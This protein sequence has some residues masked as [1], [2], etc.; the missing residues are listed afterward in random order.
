MAIKHGG[1]DKKTL[2]GQSSIIFALSMILA[3][4][5]SPSTWRRAETSTHKMENDLAKCRYEIRMNKLPEAEVQK[6]VADC[7][8]AKGYRWR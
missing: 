2:T 7:M 8:Q 5:G 3:A 6:V 4:C 1:I